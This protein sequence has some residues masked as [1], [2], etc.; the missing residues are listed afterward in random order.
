MRVPT[1]TIKKDAETAEKLMLGELKYLSL[2]MRR[3]LNGECSSALQ[4]FLQGDVLQ[5]ASI[6]AMAPMGCNPYPASP[7]I[8]LT[9]KNLK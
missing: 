1:Q 6:L 4:V 3:A 5:G 8:L 7:T 9:I 2:N